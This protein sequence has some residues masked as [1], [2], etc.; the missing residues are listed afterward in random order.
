MKHHHRITPI[1]LL[2]LLAIPAMSQSRN[3][4]RTN[5]NIHKWPGKQA[6]GSILLP[7]MWSLHP[8]GTQV[9]VADFPVNI[10]IH[11]EGKFAAILHA[12]HSTHEIHILEIATARVV[13][14]EKI[15]ET[16]YGIE[17]SGNG[18]T[19]Y[20]SGSSLEAVR[21]FEFEKQTG[22]LAAQAPIPLQ[23]SLR[24]PTHFM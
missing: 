21:S 10:A 3:N 15:D 13:H 19:L 17:F 5:D 18:K 6:D 4:S 9:Q 24:T 20:T 8:A 11:P 1:A 12:G 2:L 14:Q 23:D 22:A 7:N 16:F